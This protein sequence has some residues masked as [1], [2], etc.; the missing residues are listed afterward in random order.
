M[1]LTFL[2][3]LHFPVAI[4]HA[5]ESDIRRMNYQWQGKITPW[6]IK[7]IR[8][9]TF[10]FELSMID[11]TGTRTH[12]HIQKFPFQHLWCQAEARGEVLLQPS[13]SGPSLVDLGHLLPAQQILIS[14]ILQL[15]RT[16]WSSIQTDQAQGRYREVGVR[17]CGDRIVWHA[18]LHFCSGLSVPVS[19]G[20]LQAPIPS[21]AGTQVHV[22]IGCISQTR[23][24]GVCE[25]N[26]KS[27]Q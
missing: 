17:L 14:F 2:Q 16:R 4:C 20:L 26:F 9:S 23:F 19:R 5:W 6:S 1:R 21:N 27:Y 22:R 11:G 8:H 25:K 18:L 13:A 24:R 10:R 7:S 12:P 15:S 3:Y